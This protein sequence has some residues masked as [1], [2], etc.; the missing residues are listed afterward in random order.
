MTG[1]PHTMTYQYILRDPDANVTEVKDLPYGKTVAIEMLNT[2]GF[3]SSSGKFDFF[4]IENFG[5]GPSGKE[6]VH[7]PVISVTQYEEGLWGLS[8]IGTTAFTSGCCYAQNDIRLFADHLSRLFCIEKYQDRKLVVWSSEAEQDH[9]RS[10]TFNLSLD[11][12]NTR[13]IVEITICWP[14]HPWTCAK[15]FSLPFIRGKEKRL[16][17]IVVVPHLS[18]ALDF[19][20]SMANFLSASISL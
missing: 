2:M 17:V 19:A 14:P 3:S 5:G 12:L 4:I 9:P 10:D 20:S 18:A 1:V 13:K 7:I 8:D 16:E 11:A 15:R 6:N